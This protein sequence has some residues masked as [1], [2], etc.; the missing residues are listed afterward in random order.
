MRWGRQPAWAVAQLSGP[1]AEPRGWWVGG[2][3]VP[4]PLQLAYLWRWACL[5]PTC[6]QLPNL[7]SGGTTGARREC[8]PPLLLSLC[9]HGRRCSV[10]LP[11][12]TLCPRWLDFP[13]SPCPALISH[14]AA[15]LCR[16]CLPTRCVPR[17][18]P[19]RRAHLHG[20]GAL[21]RHLP[22]RSGPA[23]RRR[24]ALP[25]APFLRV[26][27]GQRLPHRGQQVG[28]RCHAAG[29]ARLPL[30]RCAHL[31]DSGVAHT[32]VAGPTKSFQADERKQT[33]LPPTPP[34]PHPTHTLTHTPPPP[35]TFPQV[36]APGRVPVRRPR[37]P[38]RPLPRI[39]AC[40]LPA[41][42][43]AGPRLAATHHARPGRARRWGRAARSVTRHAPWEC[44]RR[45]M[46]CAST[47]FLGGSTQH[48]QP[49]HGLLAP[50]A[51]LCQLSSAG[52]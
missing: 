21:G 39:A 33:S 15:S 35:P 28:G 29:M 12:P 2:R 27:L 38:Q 31:L 46:H 10:P 32:S 51:G 45:S 50:S 13:L 22:A 40:R 44:I 17:P 24:Q 6:L 36:P 11:L 30:P 1:G 43:V 5:L 14:T 16:G 26:P 9:A 23:Q 34:H 8:Q 49:A 19:C 48:G 18:P 42:R 37:H 20:L 3:P 4:Q 25:R 7:I 47:I 52:A 41:G